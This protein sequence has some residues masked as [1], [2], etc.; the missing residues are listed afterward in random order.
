MET[1]NRIIILL[2][3]TIVAILLKFSCHK[4]TKHVEVSD[5][6]QYVRALESELLKLSKEYDALSKDVAEAK[7]VD[8][9]TVYKYKQVVRVVKQ[10]A[11]DTC[12]HYINLVVAAADSV[13]AG[14]D[15]VIERQDRVIDNLENISAKKDTVITVQ[16][17]AIEQKTDS[18]ANQSKRIIKLEKGRK[19]WFGAG[20]SF[21]RL[22]QVGY[23]R[24]AP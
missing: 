24:I 9:V 4:E 16:K 3:V 20:M 21:D 15:T 8:T 5:T 7:R 19:W 13:I 12:Q 18:I 10:E 2:C 11:P 22:L 17:V 1:R 23:N 14:K 6:L